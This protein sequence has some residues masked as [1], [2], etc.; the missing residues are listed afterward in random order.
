MDVERARCDVHVAA[1]SVKKE[2]ERRG[3][4]RIRSD[5]HRLTLDA[6]DGEGLGVRGLGGEKQCDRK[7]DWLNGEFCDRF[8]AT[9]K[10][11]RMPE[12][13]ARAIPIPAREPM[14]PSCEEPEESAG[15]R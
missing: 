12:P 5:H 1:M 9:G 10:T 13:A 4:L 15:A 14:K 11:D 3:A 8:R 6:V 7:H 2:H